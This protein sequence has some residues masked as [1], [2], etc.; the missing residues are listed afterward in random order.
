MVEGRRGKV[1]KVILVNMPF[2]PVQYPS[3]NLSQLKP[4][5]EAERIHCD[6]EYLNIMYLN[7][8]RQ[9]NSCKNASL[10]SILAEYVFAGDIFGPD[11]SQSQEDR[12]KEFVNC[13]NLLLPEKLRGSSIFADL[14]KLKSKAIPFINQ[15]LHKIDWAEYSIIGFYARTNQVVSAIAMARRI[16]EKWPEKTI[17]LMGSCFDTGISKALLQLFPFIDWVS[18]GE[19]EVSFPKAVVRK[20]RGEPLDGIF[21]ISYRDKGQVITQGS[22]I[23]PDIESL[24]CPDFTDYFSALS[25]WAP[26]ELKNAS[27]VLELSRGCWWGQRSQCIFCGFNA[28][29]MQFR[30][31]SNSKIYS[32][33]V[34]LNKRY[35]ISRVMII[36]ASISSNCMKNI[37]PKLSIL[38]LEELYLMTRADIKRDDLANLKSAGVKSFQVGIESLDTSILKVMC[39]GT[40]ALQNIQILKWTREYGLTVNWNF[41][42]GIPGES[43]ESYKRMNDLIPSISHLRP[44]NNVLRIRLERFSP[45]L[46]QNSCRTH[47]IRPH[48]AYKAIYPFSDEDIYELA[49]FFI[50]E[51]E[52]A[53]TD[54]DPAIIAVKRKIEDWR[55]CWQGKPPVLAFRRESDKRVIIYDTRPCR[56]SSKIELEKDYALI[57]SL[58]DSEKRFCRL[59][60]YLK[61]SQREN[62]QGD[63]KLRRQL[64][65]LT[66]AR[67][68]VRDGD[69]YLSLANDLDTFVSETQ[70]LL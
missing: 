33:F 61:K 25:K 42:Y 3:P 5:L 17:V 37:L 1:R 13:D 55:R 47:N 34:T 60:S 16:K 20:F 59:A 46:E 44:P 9:P 54:I 29:G 70:L 43:S 36:D 8:S 26:A 63:Y 51:E 52:T 28:G 49:S 10:Y 48:P 23:P 66:A 7:Y 21:G 31:K 69:S 27:I 68:I 15:C 41:L 24:P 32:E 11:W 58:C 12:I 19:A 50:F 67:L 22:G 45:I 56:I 64:D 18:V 53:N 2:S 35:G 39:K 30:E 14:Q 6:I 57:Y 4:I 62:Y 40:R 65:E 38:G